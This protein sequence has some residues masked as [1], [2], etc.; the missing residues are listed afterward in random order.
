MIRHKENVKWADDVR[1]VKDGDTYAFEVDITTM[2][3]IAKTLKFRHTDVVHLF[4]LIARSVQDI[5]EVER[6]ASF[7]VCMRRKIE[8]HRNK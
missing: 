2:G 4:S 1:A 5:P 3:G 6:E 8:A 7:E